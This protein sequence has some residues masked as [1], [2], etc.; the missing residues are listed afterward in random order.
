MCLGSFGTNTYFIENDT[1]VIL[2]DPAGKASKIIEMFGDKKL[3]AIL[4]THGHFDHIK[5]VDELYDTYK[6]PVYINE[7]DEAL[8]RDKMQCLAF[9][10]PYSPVVSC[11]VVHLKEGKLKISSFEFE[12]IFTPGHTKGST[13][14]KIENYLITGDTLFKNSVGRTDLKGGDDRELK[15]SLRIIKELDPEL[16]ILPGHEEI[17]TLKEELENN[18]FLL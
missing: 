7:K 3:L 5:A 17:S 8:C 14:F 15:A 16:F 6:I 18:P 9:G 1:E 11:P 10:L 2:V 12:V 13:C 4:L